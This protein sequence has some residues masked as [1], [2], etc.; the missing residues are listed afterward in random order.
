MTIHYVLYPRSDID[1]LAQPHKNEGIGFPHV[2]I[3]VEKEN[4]ALADYVK[5]SPE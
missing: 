4:C 3:T 2:K 5:N 1:R